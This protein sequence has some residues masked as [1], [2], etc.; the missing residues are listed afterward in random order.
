MQQTHIVHILLNKSELE[1]RLRLVSGSLPVTITIVSHV[2][3]AT[4]AFMQLLIS[5]KNIFLNVTETLTFYIL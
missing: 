4:L 1:L 5:A 3:T 2:Y